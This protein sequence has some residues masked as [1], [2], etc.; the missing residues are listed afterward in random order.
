[1]LQMVDDYEQKHAVSGDA[2]RRDVD[3][4]HLGTYGSLAS[5]SD[6]PGD[7]SSGY[8]ESSSGE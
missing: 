8:S 6:R 3:L 4:I 7:G 1:M 2:V 5:R